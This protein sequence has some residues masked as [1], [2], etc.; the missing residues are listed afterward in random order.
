MSSL[1]KGQ[2][3][4]G[5][6]IKSIYPN[7]GIV[8]CEGERIV[9]K[10]VLEGQ[11]VN[12]R[13]S[14][15]RNGRHE[16][17]LVEV[18]DR[19]PLETQEPFCPHFELC[20]GC[21]YQRL[22]YDALLNL[23]ADQVKN[24]LDEAIAGKYEYEF[25]GIAASPNEKAYRNKMEF[26]FGDSCKDGE[27]TL[28][29]HKAGSFYDILQIT[30]CKIT[31]EDYNTIIRF[32]IDLCRK[33]KLTYCHKMTHEGFLR[34]LLI[35]RAAT[36]GEILVN[37]VTTS[38]WDNKDSL[39]TEESFLKEF[40][41]GL[42]NLN[43]NGNIVGILH[44]INDNPADAVKADKII[45]LT[46]K[47]FFFEEIL[48]Q[49]FKITTFSFFQTNSFG[50]E[51]LY[52]IVRD[53]IGDTKDKNV[54]DLYSGTG[55]IAQILAPVAKSVTGVEIVP[56][57]VESAKMNAALNLLSNCEF[58]CG[59]VLKVLDEIKIKPDLIVLDPPREGIHPKALTKIINYGVD[60]I[61]YVSCKPTSLA[62]DLEVFNE[63][64]YHVVKAKCCDMFPWTVHVET[65][66]ELS[67]Q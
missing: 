50:A 9:V 53:F 43:L 2:D 14:K 11:T 42:Q 46:G 41:E 36:T 30:D 7:K 18:L 34:H 13:L 58:I 38:Q 32:T 64:G 48:G 17:K 20:G 63:N 62:R 29:L 60:R 12:F 15:I 19:S 1:K 31:N 40:T 37:L 24:I 26:S 55:T 21:T 65:V 5:K 59:D 47:D 23:K 4:T 44:S 35:R 49:I 52:K 16:G 33:W 6:V 56:E 39:Q 25:M 27:L 28:G 22:T 10:N 66:V 8:E 51:V 67:R 61:V 57:A 3:Y 45:V 54:F